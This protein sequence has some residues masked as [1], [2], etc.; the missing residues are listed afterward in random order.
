MGRK[1]KLFSNTMIFGAGTFISKVLV[2][3]L[4][5]LYTAYLST[6]EFGVADIIMQTANLIIPIAVLGVSDGLF[7][8]TLD[9][10]PNRRKQIFSV[11]ILMLAIGMAPLA[12]IIQ[13]FR[14][15]SV[16][17]DF[18][19]LLFFYI[20]AANLHMI[21]ANYVRGCDRT[22]VYAFQGIVN[23]VLVIIFNVLFLVVFDMGVTGYLLSVV[24]ADFLVSVGLIIFCRLYKD[25]RFGGMSKT[26]SKELFKFSI[27][28]IPL[29]LMWSI[30]SASDRFVILAVM[31]ENATAINGLYAAAYKLPT[32][33]TIAGGIFIKA[34][35]IS[36]VSE[37]D[38]NERASFFG[39]VYKNYLSLMF[40]GGA[41][42]IAFSRLFTKIL[43]NDSY[44]DSWK[45]VPVLAIA[46]V[47]SAFS[48]FLGSIYFVHKN[49]VRSLVTAAFGAGMNIALN[50]ALIP[51][52][53]AMGAAIATAVCYAIVFLIRLIDTRRLM[54]FNRSV[55]KTVVNTVLILEQ[56]VLMIFDP[57]FWWIYQI[58]IV[59][60]LAVFNGKDIVSALLKIIKRK[61]I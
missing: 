59:A 33:I 42:L 48:E 40:T 22:K 7:R 32:L 41:F 5:P 49:S 16:Y 23:T 30:T 3:L 14:L 31:G 44:Y 20:C 12:I 52:L 1:K 56:A 55:V 54:S 10:D 39:N 45:F 18:V 25:I 28:Y 2:F 46:M 58:C 47:F 29:T 15:S 26:L 17:T 24:L 4:M 27:P 60:F 35:Q 51:F 6:E 50:F 36:S 43:L 8:F 34:W 57:P 21:V 37:S 9:A 53:G 19:W 38:A 13:L 61:K 11:A